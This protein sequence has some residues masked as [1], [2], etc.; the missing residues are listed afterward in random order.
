MQKQKMKTCIT[1]KES[2]SYLQLKNNLK[3]THQKI[4]GQGSFTDKII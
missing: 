2:E 3:F 1:T 4:P